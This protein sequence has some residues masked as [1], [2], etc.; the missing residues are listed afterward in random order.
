MVSLRQRLAVC[1]CCVGTG[2]YT[3]SAHSTARAVVGMTLLQELAHKT[4]SRTAQCV[5]ATSICTK[6]L[7]ACVTCAVCLCVQ[8]CLLR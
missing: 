8:V 3:H 1:A 2:C 6:L 4:V 5:T 7:F